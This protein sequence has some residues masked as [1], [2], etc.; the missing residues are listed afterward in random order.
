MSKH[1]AILDYGLGNLFSIVQGCANVGLKSEITNKNKIIKES[2]GLI[3]PGVGSFGDAMTK[4]AELE[5]I[6]TIKDFIASGKPVMGICLGMQILFSRSE[7]FGNYTG[8]DVIS[9]KI[10]KFPNLSGSKKIK[11]PQIGWNKIYKS[12]P[13]TLENPILEGVGN[14]EFMYFVHSYYAKPDS[15]GVV[16]TT[17]NYEGTDYCS[18]VVKE[19]VTAFQF[20][21]EKSAGKG[22]KI[23]ENWISQLK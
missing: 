21:P 11:V 22:L 13:L 17:T 7:E 16:L 4:L 6:D 19:N 14:G 9:G 23:Y 3:L 12:N 20:H 8:L 2:D 1:V 18:A 5:L 15:N 10:L